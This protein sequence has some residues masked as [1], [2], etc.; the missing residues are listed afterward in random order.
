MNIC[1]FNSSMRSGGAERIIS[2]LS[3]LYAKNGDHVI[4]VTY[5]DQDSFYPLRSGINH[6][7]LGLLRN[8]S[9]KL[10]AVH[11]SWKRIF[12]LR[13]V[14][15]MKRIDVLLTF[16]SN[17]EFI[18]YVAKIGLNCKLIGAERANPFLSSNTFWNRYKKRI[19]N[20]CDGFI[21]QTKGAS[22]YF[23]K[24]LQM[25]GY[26]IPNGINPNDFN[27][28]EREWKTRTNLCAVGRL[29]ESKCF[30]DLLR[31]VAIV[32]RSHPNI[33]LDVYGD[34]PKRTELKL[35]ASELGLDDCVIFHGQCGT[36][37]EEY[38]SHKIFIMTSQQEGFPNVLL[39][40][41]A[42]GCACISTNCDFG[43][44]EL[45]ND[46]VNGFLVPV[47]DYK[48]IAEKV[49]TLIE[50]DE[51]AESFSVEAKKVRVTHD[52]NSIGMVLYRYLQD[53]VNK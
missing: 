38:A 14:L 12:R 36:V 11:Y 40:A 2:L 39:E 37:L 7:R 33:K 48:L 51:L 47:H 20:L 35:L 49:C 10:Q 26:I 17:T 22:E 25:K 31:A 41:M 1:F 5:D 27:K 8:S 53:V 18:G 50:D 45:I 16:D 28:Y 46:G 32:H 9:T 30:D 13:Q 29:I 52:I 6:I 42:S 23:S 15:K 21:F 3:E 44:S 34:G 24:S 4:I 43:P 19:A